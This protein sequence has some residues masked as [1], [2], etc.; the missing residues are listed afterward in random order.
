MV[1]FSLVNSSDWAEHSPD[2]VFIQQTFF[3]STLIAS[4]RPRSDNL[5]K[6]G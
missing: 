2:V 4:A 3:K 5:G 1:P 6:Y